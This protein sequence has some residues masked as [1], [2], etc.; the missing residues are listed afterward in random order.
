MADHWLGR[1]IALQYA[2]EQ[3]PALEKT[4]RRYPDLYHEVF[5]E[6]KRDEVLTDLV[7]MDSNAFSGLSGDGKAG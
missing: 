4:V 3:D 7:W 2:T 1:L 5:N 6:P